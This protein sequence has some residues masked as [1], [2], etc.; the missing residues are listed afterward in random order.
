MFQ[1]E[2]GPNPSIGTLTRTYYALEA[3]VENLG[4]SLYLSTLPICALGTVTLVVEPLA[5]RLRGQLSSLSELPIPTQN[6][7]WL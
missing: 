5:H 1:V 2:S 3:Y 6:I 4:T 7:L